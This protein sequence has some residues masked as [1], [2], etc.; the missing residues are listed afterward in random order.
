L[1]VIDFLITLPVAVLGY[2]AFPDTPTTTTAR[3]LTPEERRLAVERIPEPD[4]TRGVLGWS[5]VPRVLA[6]WHWWGFVLIWI[7]ASNCQ[8]FSTNAVMNLWLSYTDDYSVEEVNYIPTGVSAVGIV[9]TV[10]LGMYTDYTKRRWHAGIILS[11]TAIVSGAIMLDPPSRGGKFFALFLN[12]SQYAAQA[13]LFAWANDL[14]KDDDAKRSVILA[15]MNTFA[16]AVYMFWSLVFYN[17]TQVPNWREG[18]IAMLVM[19]SLLFVSTLAVR[20]MQTRDERKSRSVHDGLA[21]YPSSK[22]VEMQ[23]GDVHVDADP[24]PSKQEDTL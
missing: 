9:A 2:F 17:A 15:G 22:D 10:A 21:P 24:V 1:F 6:T 20:Y 4:K 14:T 16:I 23:K 8:M 7:F 3:Y 11:L 5:L 12:G 18:S 19:G 13:V